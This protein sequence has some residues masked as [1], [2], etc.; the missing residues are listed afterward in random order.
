MQNLTIEYLESLEYSWT[1][2]VE[3]H[4]GVQVSIWY[5]ALPS[6]K[7]II[8]KVISVS[9]DYPRHTI[10]KEMCCCGCDCWNK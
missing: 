4:N 9:S 3:Y 8:A 1:A 10:R 7:G 6:S 2:E 5:T